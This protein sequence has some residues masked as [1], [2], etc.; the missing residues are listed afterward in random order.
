MRDPLPWDDPERD[1]AADIADWKRWAISDAVP[2]DP[3]PREDLHDGGVVMQTRCVYCG[4]EHYAPLVW[5]IS[6]GRVS[7]DSCGRIPPVFTSKAEYREARQAH[8][9]FREHP[10]VTE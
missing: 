7:C 8:R 4:V 3:D 2:D 5:E 9:W 6:H 10:E 1:I